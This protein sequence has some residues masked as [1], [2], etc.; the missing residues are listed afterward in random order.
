[1]ESVCDF[2]NE[3][4]RRKRNKYCQRWKEILMHIPCLPWAEVMCTLDQEPWPSS[5]NFHWA[6]VDRQSSI[7]GQDK[8][9]TSF[10]VSNMVQLSEDWKLMTILVYGKLF[11]YLC[12]TQY[13]W[14]QHAHWVHPKLPDSAQLKVKYQDRE[15]VKYWNW[16]WLS[17]LQRHPFCTWNKVKSSS[18]CSANSACL[19]HTCC[20]C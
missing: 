1:M 17:Q 6:T 5:R 13:T 7:S 18:R 14:C 19:E 12:L 8:I 2:P 15:K 10:N 3:L 16:W 4:E 11:G 9:W 20:T